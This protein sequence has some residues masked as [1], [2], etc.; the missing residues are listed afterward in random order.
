MDGVKPK[1][2]GG[3][4]PLRW[5]GKPNDIL[6]RARTRGLIPEARMWLPRVFR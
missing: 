4:E 3:I 1:A 2:A 5:L 6:R